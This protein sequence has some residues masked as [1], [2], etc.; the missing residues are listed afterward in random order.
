MPKAGVVCGLA[1]GSRRL[2]PRSLW[3]VGVYEGFPECSG[4]PEPLELFSATWYRPVQGRTGFDQGRR[5]RTRSTMK[6]LTMLDADLWKDVVAR[7]IAAEMSIAV[8]AK[9]ADRAVD[10]FRVRLG[11]EESKKIREL[12]EGEDA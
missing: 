6:Y 11:P 5:E 2:F 10:E 12:E 3:L 4:G 9:T 7:C 1:S 8:A